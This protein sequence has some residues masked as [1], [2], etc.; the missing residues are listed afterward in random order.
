M[1]PSRGS[2]GTL[3][4][5]GRL[6]LVLGLLCCSVDSD[7]M[8][9]AVSF[10]RTSGLFQATLEYSPVYLRLCSVFVPNCLLS[11]Q[12]FFIGY[13]VVWWVLVA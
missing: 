6:C 7:S 1:R 4:I 8:L 12:E 2:H 13:N 3:R 10:P 11:Y 9:E 5:M